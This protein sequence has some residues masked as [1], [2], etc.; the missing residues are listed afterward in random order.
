MWTMEAVL[1]T[2]SFCLCCGILT[3][4]GNRRV[5]RSDS[6]QNVIPVLTSVLKSTL[7]NAGRRCTVGDIEVFINKNGFVCRNC[8]T[9]LI[10]HYTTECSLMEKAKGA[11]HLVN[12]NQGDCQSTARAKRRHSNESQLAE[13]IP[14][15]KTAKKKLHN[16]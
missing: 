16:L 13:D 15:C 10:R 3:L 8:H 2:E 1:E 6:K 14:H 4:P 5:M 7:L 9:L 11:I 12:L